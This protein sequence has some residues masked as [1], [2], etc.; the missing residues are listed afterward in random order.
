MD[1][2]IIIC[3]LVVL[4]LALL[5]LSP[6]L[7]VQ[8]QP[9]TGPNLLSPGDNTYTNDNTPYFEWENIGTENITHYRLVIDNDINFAD[10]DNSYDNQI[11]TD[12]WDNF[13]THTE[14]ALPEGT[15][16]WKV[17]AENENGWGPFS[18]TRT[19]TID[20]TSPTVVSISVSESDNIITDSEIGE[21]FTVTVQFDEN[22][23]NTVTPDVEFIPNVVG[24]TLTFDNRWW[25]S[26]NRYYYENYTISDANVEN[27]DVDIKVE[28]AKDL[29]GNLQV[30]FTGNDKFDIDTKNPT[31]V[32]IIVSDN[33]IADNDAGETFTVT[34]Q[35]DENMDNT[36][37]PD[38]EFIPN[39]VGET[40][41]FNV[42]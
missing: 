40:L 32:S 8:A 22:M 3:P 37:T 33:V 10:G 1:R 14:N 39:V 26:D 5:V 36:V 11:L 18:E 21:T 29:A 35:F 41:T 30:S 13:K 12:N 38:V 9:S 27:F 19:L 6:V 15:W 2:K 16:Y 31:V 28:N 20:V 24:E 7:I 17:Q 4:L 34:I 25:S 23:D 42:G